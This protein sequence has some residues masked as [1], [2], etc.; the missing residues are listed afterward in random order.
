V[1]FKAFL[2]ENHLSLTADHD[3]T[4]AFIIKIAS[5]KLS[6]EEIKYWI[7]NNI[8]PIIPKGSELSSR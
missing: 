1:V 7:I 4:Y 2:A 3:E 5:G 6:Y 8:Q